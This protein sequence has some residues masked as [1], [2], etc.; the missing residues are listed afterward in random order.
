LLV[1]LAVA[2]N[3]SIE[4]IVKAKDYSLAQVSR[5]AFGDYGLWFTVGFAII[6]TVSGVIASLFAISRMLTMLTNMNLVPHSDFGIP[7]TIQKHA[8]VYTTIIAMLL[9]IFF[10]LSR[11]ASLGA[12][13]TSSWILLYIGACYG[14]CVKKLKLMLPF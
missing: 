3:L 12:I 6:A 11:I 13:F 8:L 5:P 2:A 14:I 7:G 9:T 1:S 10:D 4:E